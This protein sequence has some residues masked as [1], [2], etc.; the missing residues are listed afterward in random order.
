MQNHHAF[1]LK[2]VR[3][4]SLLVRLTAIRKCACLKRLVNENEAGKGV[5]A[6]S[7]QADAGI[8]EAVARRT[9][10]RANG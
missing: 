5:T 1:M 7:V 9:H 2:N 3:T 6:G 8:H 10:I 4:P